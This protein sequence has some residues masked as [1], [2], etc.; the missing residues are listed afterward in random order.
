MAD[1]FEVWMIRLQQLTVLDNILVTDGHESNI[2]L[3]FS[4][5]DLLHILGNIPIHFVSK[6]KYIQKIYKI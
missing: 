2:I 6:N 3:I 5:C 1:W 4:I